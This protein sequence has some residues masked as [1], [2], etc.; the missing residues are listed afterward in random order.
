MDYGNVRLA[1]YIDTLERRI[2]Q[3]EETK[4]YGP[5]YAIHHI[6]GNLSNNSLDNLSLHN[7]REH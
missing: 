6:D 2:K 4:S 7:I 5:E 1:E 3:L